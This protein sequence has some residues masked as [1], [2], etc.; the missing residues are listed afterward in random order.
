[1]RFFYLLRAHGEERVTLALYRYRPGSV[2]SLG[3]LVGADAQQD[4][5]NA[6]YG[7]ALWMLIQCATSG[8][9]TFPSWHDMFGKKKEAVEETADEIKNRIIRD[10]IAA[11]ITITGRR[12]IG[13]ESDTGF[14]HY[15]IE[16]EKIYELEE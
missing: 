9:S 13:Y 16:V 3:M 15:V 11:D 12:F 4:A 8:G 6:Y 7:S 2:R 1:M 10:L 14:Y 5:K